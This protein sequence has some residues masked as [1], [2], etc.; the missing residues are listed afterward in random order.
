MGGWDDYYD[1]CHFQF[2]GPRGL[3]GGRKKERTGIDDDEILTIQRR[4]SDMRS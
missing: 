1:W 3:E 4:I 2:R